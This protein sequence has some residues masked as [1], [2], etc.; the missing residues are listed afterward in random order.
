MPAL[1]GEALDE[2][3]SARRPRASWVVYVLDSGYCGVAGQGSH[4]GDAVFLLP[5]L[6]LLVLREQPQGRGYR[7]VTPAY[8]E[9]VMNCE[10]QELAGELEEIVLV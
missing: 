1:D 5:P 4:L 8:C 7:I 9:G 10:V 6:N 3:V 2:L